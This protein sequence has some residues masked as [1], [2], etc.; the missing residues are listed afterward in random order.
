MKKL[1]KSTMAIMLAFIIAF[2]V[3]T[4]CSFAEDSTGGQ[5]GEDVYWSV[6]TETGLLTISGT[7]K[8]YDYTD[9]T[10]NPFYCLSSV[11][12]L[13]IEDG[14]TSVSDYCFY[15][16]TGLESIEIPESVEYIGAWAF[17]GS[18]SLE[19]FIVSENNAYYVSDE[20]GVLYSKDMKNLIQY[21]AG[22]NSQ[23]YKIKNGVEVLYPESF[24]HAQN[25][26]YIYLPDTVKFIGYGTFTLCTGLEKIVIPKGVEEIGDSAFYCCSGLKRI[27][28]PNTVYYIG[29]YAFY[30]CESLEYALIPNSVTEIG[31]DAFAYCYELENICYFGTDE[32]WNNING[33][34]DYTGTSAAVNTCCSEFGGVVFSTILFNMIEMVQKFL[35]NIKFNMLLLNK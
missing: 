28:V 8:M 19:K 22:N 13:V 25:L 5:C 27:L 33:E 14:I 20:N 6:D 12:S 16:C 1:L 10:Q 4:I 3:F 11:S 30:G 2:S 26:N 15:C 17:Y 34:S 9:G 7:G 24:N 35:V 29:E 32:D 23:S 31:K 21:P 18:D